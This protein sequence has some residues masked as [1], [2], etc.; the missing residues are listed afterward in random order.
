MIKMLNALLL[1]STTNTLFPVVSLENFT[2]GTYLLAPVHI[3]IVRPGRIFL[4]SADFR[5]KIFKSQ[6]YYL[7]KLLASGLFL[8]Y[9]LKFA[10]F[11]IQNSLI[12]KRGQL[13]HHWKQGS[14]NH[15]K[16]VFP[17]A[18]EFIL[19]MLRNFQAKSS[20]QAKGV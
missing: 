1:M 13:T 19:K 14:I 11:K 5:L 16:C 15:L 8:K 10:N 6:N 12:K 2:S 20:D 9:S 17:S 18:H 4:F 3:G 7:F